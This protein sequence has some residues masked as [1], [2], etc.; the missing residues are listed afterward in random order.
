MMDRDELR[1]ATDDWVADGII[2]PDQATQILARHE[3]TDDGFS[4]TVVALSLM[5]ATLFGI[6]VVL[7]LAINWED[8]PRW[9]GTLIVV[10][11]PPVFGA[12]GFW[13]R[14]GR[15][16]R[17]GHALWLLGAAFVGPSL[18]LLT[19]LWALEIAEE[20]LLFG[21]AAVAVPAGHAAES[22]PTTALGLVV[23]SA[24]VIMLSTPANML[25]TAGLFGVVLLGIGL[26]HQR[27][28]TA[29]TSIGGI[30]RFVG[31]STVI[32]SLFAALIG[33]S[34]V[35]AISVTLSLPF[36]AA[37]PSVLSALSPGMPGT[38]VS[39][40]R[41]RSGSARLSPQWP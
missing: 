18:I 5:G 17:V 22:R 4:R 36:S 7:I 37:L 40:A 24:L 28:D 15:A 6:G 31:V 2:S 12:V 23:V 16:P 27:R 33:L 34:A 35:E 1:D 39:S 30:Y 13:L 19:D 14:D 38:P 21:W 29:D 25:A 20:W 11:A 32:I 9:L 10:T 8:I 3:E 41:R 26:D